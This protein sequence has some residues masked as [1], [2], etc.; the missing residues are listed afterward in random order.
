VIEALRAERLGRIFAALGAAA[1]V[2]ILAMLIP[3]QP[4]LAIGVGVLLLAA[5]LVLAAPALL[6]A[7]VFATSFAYWRV[8]PTSVNMSVGDAVTLLALVAALPYVPWRSRTLR[9]I[10]AGLA[11]YL[12]LLLVTVLGHATQAAA[13]EWLHRAVLF[14]GAIV[15]GA[16]VAHRGQIAVALKA[17]VYAAAIIAV[18]SIYSALTSGF[19]PAYP[20]G[21]NKNAAGPLLAMVVVV[22]IVAPWRTGIRPL[23]VRHLRILI[24]V[25]LLAT[26]SRGAA[27]SLVAVVAIYAM[28]HRSA[29]QRAPMFFLAA[30]LALIAASVVTLQDQ[31]VNN[32]DF[33]GIVL[34]A[35]T[36]DDALNNV[37]ADHPY[38]GGGLKY[39]KS[40]SAQAGGAE[41]IFVTELAEAGI[42]GLI[43]LIGLLGNTLRVLLPRRDT[44]G[45]TAFL[46]FVLEILFALTAIFWIAGTLTLPMLL[47]G[48]AAGEETTTA[49]RRTRGSLSNTEA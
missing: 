13:T 6:L 2:V 21:M 11:F 37:W 35:N 14:G 49:A 39:F 22:L 47:V 24:V 38:V 5:G 41:Q 8:G 15:I 9:K 42:I 34:R 30:M 46:V 19:Q 23:T 28:R 33:N 43:G 17:V 48:L 40:A 45:E 44:I 27:L 26:Q 12:G 25:G 20:F 4:S 32:P 1:L 36:I 31:Q 18:A 3:S 10:L 7:A 29:R 16:A